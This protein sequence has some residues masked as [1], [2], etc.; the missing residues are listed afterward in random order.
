MPSASNLRHELNYLS[1]ASHNV[2]WISNV[3][4]KKC[5]RLYGIHIKHTVQHLTTNMHCATFI[6]PV[7]FFRFFFNSIPPGE[8][9]AFTIIFNQVICK[10]GFV[11]ESPHI[12]RKSPQKDGDNFFLRMAICIFS[13]LASFLLQNR[14]LYVKRYF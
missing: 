10:N 14:V 3:Y 11:H 4:E 6:S 9:S 8:I 2:A 1:N 12:S 7:F 13:L 5:S